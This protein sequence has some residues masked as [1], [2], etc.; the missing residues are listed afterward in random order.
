MPLLFI[1]S[2]PVFSQNYTL[3][4]ALNN[5]TVSTCSGAF[6]DSGGAG[7]NYGNNQNR[8]VTVLF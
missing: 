4:N 3:N 8:T 1:V 6:Y 7:G 5:T 2:A